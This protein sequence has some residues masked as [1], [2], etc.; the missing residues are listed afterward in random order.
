MRFQLVP[1]SSTVD[2]LELLKVQIFSEFC[3][4]SHVREAATTAKRTKIDPYSLRHQCSP[5]T[6][7][8]GNNYYKAHADVRGGS[9]GWIVK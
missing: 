3:D 2:D 7:V 1:K 5:M 4:I 9:S 6:L 8:S